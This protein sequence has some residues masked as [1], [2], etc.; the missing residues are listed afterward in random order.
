MATPKKPSAAQAKFIRAILNRGTT[1]V[2]GPALF[3][4]R[5][6]ITAGGNTLESTKAR[7]WVRRSERRGVAYW[8]VTANGCVAVGVRRIYCPL[9]GCDVAHEFEAEMDQHVLTPHT[10]TTASL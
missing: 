6:G 1:N 2:P 10:A 5:D 7:G 9:T 8:S 3:S 4:D